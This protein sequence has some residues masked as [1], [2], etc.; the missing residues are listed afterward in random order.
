MPRKVISGYVDCACRDCMNI[1]IASDGKPA[2]CSDCQE[3]GC[4]AGADKEC[5]APGAYGDLDEAAAE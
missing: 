4:E 1:A 5:Q 3:A 2:L